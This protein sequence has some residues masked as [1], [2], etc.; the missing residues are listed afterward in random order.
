MVWEAG[1]AGKMREVVRPGLHS[2]Q[3]KYT[4]VFLSYPCAAGW[5]GH[6]F[7]DGVVDWGGTGAACCYSLCRILCGL[8]AV[9]MGVCC[10]R[11]TGKVC[12]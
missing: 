2:R 3:G 11:F 12:A 4:C 7:H 1:D 5:I 8:E 10:A 9:N 6:V